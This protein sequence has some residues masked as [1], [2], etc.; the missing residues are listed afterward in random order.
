M[1]KPH[2]ICVEVEDHRMARR[3]D[4][5]N[6]YSASQEGR[7]ASVRQLQDYCI[8]LACK[9]NS[10]AGDTGENAVEARRRNCPKNKLALGQ[11]ETHE[12]RL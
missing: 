10:V 3:M 9:Q 2:E 4:K 1:T 8:G 6:I 11:K 12:I 7:S 5:I